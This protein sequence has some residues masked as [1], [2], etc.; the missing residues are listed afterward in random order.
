M[1]GTKRFYEHMESKPSSNITR[2]EYNELKNRVTQLE[3]FVKSL[4]ITDLV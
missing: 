2:K 4:L 3:S 1:G